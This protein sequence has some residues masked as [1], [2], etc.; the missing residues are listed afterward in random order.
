M[1]NNLASSEGDSG[2][3]G[4]LRDPAL[5][6]TRRVLPSG[7]TL[8]EAGSAADNLFLIQNGQVR[9]Y[10]LSPDGSRRLLNICGPGQ[11]LSVESL[12]A[13][14]YT[15]FAETAT[16]TIVLLVPAQ[17][18][19]EALPQYPQVCVQLIRQLADQ[20]SAA[21][22]DACGLVFDDCRRRL[23][24]ALLKF[25]HSAAATATHDGILL[26]M[27]HEQLAQA[28][29]AARKT[30]DQASGHAVFALG[31]R[32]GTDPVAGGSRLQPVLDMVEGAVGG[33]HG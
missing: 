29:G 21:T 19:L 11:W 14:V 16:D 24:K 22:Q 8:H 6:V 10:Q 23:L 18:L 3:A 15:C 9:Q 25:S 4:L 7:T 2:L 27:T 17:R 12:G 20:V 31:N 13:S 30:E 32:G 26:R 5:G 1:L 28:V 33:R